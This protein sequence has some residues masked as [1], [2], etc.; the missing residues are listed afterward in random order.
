MTRT[1]VMTT[2]LL[3][4]V[5]C[6]KPHRVVASMPLES[7]QME[8]ASSHANVRWSLHLSIASQE[9]EGIGPSANGPETPPV[10]VKFKMQQSDFEGLVLYV[11]D[12]IDKSDGKPCAP[13]IEVPGGRSFVIATETTGSSYVLSRNAS[14]SP[15]HT[16]IDLTLEQHQELFRRFPTSPTTTR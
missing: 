6:A 12:L 7:M 16:C 11:H 4:S 10:P 5:G 2:L 14:G 9:V 3:A 1:A 8:A 13:P 15:K